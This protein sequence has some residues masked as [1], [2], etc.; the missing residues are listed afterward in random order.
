MNQ[1]IQYQVQL[2]TQI[3]SNGR[4]QMLPAVRISLDALSKTDHLMSE[5]LGMEIDYK[6]ILVD[7]ETHQ[8]SY[9]VKLK[10][11]RPSQPFLDPWP[12]PDKLQNWMSSIRSSLINNSNSI[13]MDK[14][15]RN[16]A[17]SWNHWAHEAGF[18]DGIV[19]TKFEPE[20]L[21]ILLKC[22]KHGREA[23]GSKG[24]ILITDF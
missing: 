1:E 2:T 8:F 22:M 3:Q 18:T 15:I 5:K 10:L 14:E 13:K 23:L 20:Q 21:A 9:T 24:S 17:N 4:R 19:Y 7:M 16:I 12:E 6:Q 11:H